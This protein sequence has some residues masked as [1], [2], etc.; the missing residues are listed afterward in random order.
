MSASAGGLQDPLTHAFGQDEQ[1][2]RSLL[3]PLKSALEESASFWRDA[4]LEAELRGY[5]FERTYM[6]IPDVKASAIGGQFRFTSGNWRNFSLSAA[7]YNATDVDSEGGPNG[8]TPQPGKNTNVWGEANLRYDI[9]NTALSGSRLTLYR[10][11]LSLPYLNK[12]DVRM[13]PATH[14]GYLLGRE[15]SSL[16]YMVGHVT[17]FKGYQSD[18]FVNMSE[19][20]GALNSDDGVSVA[21]VQTSVGESAK[22]G[23]IN[24]YGWN[25]F[26]TAYLEASYH[27][28]VTDDLDVR[29]SG[30]HTDQRSTGDEL[31]GS[32]HTHHSAARVALGWRG[33]V[34]S[35]G[36]STTAKNS[37]IRAP[38]GGK[39]SYLSLMRNDFDR[40]GEDAILLGLSYNTDYFSALGLSSYV[41]IVHGRNAHT[42]LQD[43]APNQ[44]EYDLT[45]D[46]KP[47]TGIFEGLWARLR[48]AY[49]DADG[50]GAVHD[51]RLIL[52]YSLPL[53]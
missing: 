10:Q 8:L 20:A 35:L 31:V 47:P 24:Y 49:V 11:T 27:Q 41:N 3:R 25:T 22:V 16:D 13:V 43:K 37:T 44:T 32:F 26:N 17:R 39:P 19:A 14:E 36:G 29:V 6:L 28:E 42:V 15:N 9:S 21:G 12:N 50:S 48:Y 38:W 52:N 34:V 46:Y 2:D 1:S 53:L 33:A 23:L 4:K 51:I 7:W 5:R 18:R 30:Q 40:P 45:V